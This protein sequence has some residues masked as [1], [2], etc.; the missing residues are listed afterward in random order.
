[1]KKGTVTALIIA[2]VCIIAGIATCTCALAVQGF[3]ADGINTLKFDVAVKEVDE[4][5]DSLEIKSL[6]CDV[7]VLPSSDGICRVESKDSNKI[8]TEVYVSNGTLEIVRKDV[9]GWYER[10]GVWFY[11]ELSINV[12]LPDAEYNVLSVDSASGDVKI[13]DFFTFSSADISAVS[14]DINTACIVNGDMNAECTSG[15]VEIQNGANGSMTV[16]SVSGS[17]E[18][19]DIA[20]SSLTVKTTS[21][22]AEL[23]NVLVSGHVK[24]ISV[25]GDIELD[26]VDADTLDIETTSGEVSGSLLSPKNYVTQTTSG[27]VRVPTSDSSAGECRIRT[28]SGDIYFE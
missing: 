15:N 28:T 23:K 9:R 10:I 5:F 7:N 16:S 18:L 13:S 2:G 22:E 6:E 11:D 8:Y 17:I 21:G 19:S 12:Y 20:P 25:S 14:G 4:S 1:M 26:G 27:S 24:L 3:R